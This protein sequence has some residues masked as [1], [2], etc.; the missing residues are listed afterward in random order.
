MTYK[1]KVQGSSA[2]ISNFYL[3]IYLCHRH[4]DQ[5]TEHFQLPGR[6][7][8]D[9]TFISDHALRSSLL[10]PSDVLGALEFTIPSLRIEL[11]LF[12]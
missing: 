1:G 9:L 5:D 6:F 3:S 12:F 11:W 7:P 2:S 10:I 8:P 4:S